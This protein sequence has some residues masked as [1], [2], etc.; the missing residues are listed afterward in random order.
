MSAFALK[1]TS[2]R[3][4]RRHSLSTGSRVTD[5]RHRVVNGGFRR[6]NAGVYWIIVV[7]MRFHHLILDYGERRT[8]ECLF[9]REAIRCLMG[10]SV[11]EL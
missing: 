5:G 2:R 8:V 6:I 1:P 9:K 7:P 11:R 3:S 10:C 4:H